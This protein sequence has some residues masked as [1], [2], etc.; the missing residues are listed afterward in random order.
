MTAALQL[1][2]RVIAAALRDFEREQAAFL[3]HLAHGESVVSI[4]PPH[5]GSHAL[6]A[7]CQAYATV[8]YATDDEARASVECVGVVGAEEATVLQAQ[9][10][11]AAKARLQDAFA[12]LQ[13]Q[14]M[15]VRSRMPD[16]AELTRMT[17]IVRVALRQIGRPHL[18]L[19]AAYRRVPVL[20]GE[21]ARVAFTRTLTR[22]V[23]RVAREALLARL[24]ESERPGAD[25]DRARLRALRD[26]HLALVEPHAPNIRANVWLRAPD[27]SG[28]QTLQVAAELPLLYRATRGRGLP[29]IIYPSA[30]DWARNADSP[31]RPRVTRLESEPYLQTL[32]AYRYRRD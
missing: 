13:R 31:R 8:D 27:G 26:S 12:P 7:A 4:A 23:K 25:R 29:D 20:A 1:A 11:N 21:P 19:F 24:Q 32:A 15:R 14:R 3:R 28:R 6:A 9:R 5:A 10:L 2:T 22:R 16:G 18:N 30:A 17:S